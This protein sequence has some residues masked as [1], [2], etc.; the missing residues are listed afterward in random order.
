MNRPERVSTVRPPKFRDPEVTADGSPRASV[1]LSDPRTLW[2]NTG[3]VCNVA[4]TRC[5]IESSPEND[6]LV[7]LTRADVEDFLA[8]IR[9]RG[10]PVREIGFTGGEPFVNPQIIGMAEAALEAGHET[11]V[12]TNAMRPMTRPKTLAGL[13]GKWI[14]LWWY[15]K[16][17]T[18]G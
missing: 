15:P 12:L 16:A 4:C 6:R 3:T 11:L 7:Y 14:A 13:R 17:S 2:F 5:Y 8:Q 9:D 1:A 18:P 10:W